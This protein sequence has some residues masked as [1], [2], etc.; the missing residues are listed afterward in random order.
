MR[1]HYLDNIRWAT[2]LLVVLYHTIFMYNH[3][4]TVGVVGPVTD[5]RWQDALQYLL[6]PWFMVVLFL[7]SGASARYA[8]D[9]HSGKAFFAERT[10]KLLVPSTLGLLVLGWAQ[11][12]FNMAFSHAF[13]NIPSGV[14][15]PV[16]Y[17]IMTVSGIG[18]L[19]TCHV[20]WVCA[21]VLLAVRRIEGG[22]LLAKCAA[23]PYW[24][25]VLLGVAA[26]AAA[27]VLNT[28]VI[29]VYRF[30]IY[31]FSYL[32]G[33]YVFS[34]QAVVDALA[35]RAPILCGAAAVLGGG[36][37]LSQLGAE[38]RRSPQR[39]Q[40]AGHRLCVGGLS[41]DFRRYE[42]LGRPHRAVRGI[43]DAA[44]LR[45]VHLPL[46]SAVGCRL[47][48]RVLPALARRWG[49]SAVGGGSVRRRAGAVRGAAPHPGRAVLCVRHPKG[50]KPCFVTTL[51]R[52][53]S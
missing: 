50:E 24:A 4:V 14:P 51:S 10:R 34:Q 44:Q 43:Y 37:P 29:A 32:A 33:Y 11:G 25:V 27:Q 2:V 7:V 15:A 6:Y 35:R 36:V 20:L 1:K 16:L 48:P 9:S 17:L 18:V 26:W 49:V 45:A 23:L 53:A 38:L 52:C 39:E 21:L 42:A 41:G 30:G 3:V 31:L 22:R 28:P 40:P 12:Y 46:F 19:W 5:C 8:L 47:R 13:E